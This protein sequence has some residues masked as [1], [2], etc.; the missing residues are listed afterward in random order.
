MLYDPAWEKPTKGAEPAI[1]KRSLM[2]II[3]KLNPVKISLKNNKEE[4]D[5]NNKKVISR[6]FNSL[7]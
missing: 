1:K 2:D 5:S 6:I 3:K 4:K 7:F